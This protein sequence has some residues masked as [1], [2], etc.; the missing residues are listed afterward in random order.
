MVWLTAI[1]KY[2]KIIGIV[3]VVAAVLFG[4]YKVYSWGYIASETRV[5][6]DNVEAGK[7]G[8]EGARDVQSCTDRG[9]VWDASKDPGECIGL[10]T[11][12]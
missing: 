5:E 7:Q 8:V 9:G 6:R 1:W 12:R 11:G 10:E 2:R 4:L 3:A